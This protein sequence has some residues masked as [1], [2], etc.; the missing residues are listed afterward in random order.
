M[1]QFAV[2]IY[3]LD[4]AH[5]PGEDANTSPEIA[6]CDDHAES[7]S[8]STTPSTSSP[9]STSLKHLI[10]KPL[11]QWPPRIQSSARAAA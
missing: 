4:S 6:E 11:W 2:L 10:S 8:S 3:S 1:A 9:G 5:T 7:L